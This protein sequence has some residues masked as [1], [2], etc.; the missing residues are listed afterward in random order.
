LVIRVMG[1]G[2]QN[3]LKDAM[4][5]TISNEKRIGSKHN[6]LQKGDHI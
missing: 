3:M 2:Q 4:G 6:W 5:K 1:K